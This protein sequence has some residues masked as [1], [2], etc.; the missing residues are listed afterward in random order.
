MPKSLVQNPTQEDTG[1]LPQGGHS[2]PD[3]PPSHPGDLQER[4]L[5]AS[6]KIVTKVSDEY[7]SVFIFKPYP[8][9]SVAIGKSHYY[10]PDNDSI[11]DLFHA[12]EKLKLF[13]NQEEPMAQDGIKMTVTLSVEGSENVTLTLTYGNTDIETVKLVEAALL[14]TL[15]KLVG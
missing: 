14:D 8:P 4:P 6:D 9:Y 12:L 2:V 15:K 5:V 13:V 1:N 7:G 10:F 11:F 3:N